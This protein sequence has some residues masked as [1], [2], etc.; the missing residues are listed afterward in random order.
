MTA[1]F[2]IGVFIALPIAMFVAYALGRRSGRDE[3]EKKLSGEKSA[4]SVER[5]SLHSEAKRNLAAVESGKRKNIGAAKAL[6]SEQGKVAKQ[7]RDLEERERILKEAEDETR[8]RNQFLRNYFRRRNRIDAYVGR[9][10]LRRCGGVYVISRRD[11]L[12]KVGFTEDDF[13][14]RFKEVEQDC[15]KAGI[16][17]LQPEILVPMDEGITEVEKEVHNGFAAQRESG[18]WFRVSVED[19]VRAVRA[20][21]WRQHL[22]NTKD[23]KHLEPPDKKG[24]EV[25]GDPDIPRG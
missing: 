22:R 5:E 13:S 25:R 6:K 18:E 7:R 9:D 11:G 23:R 15:R 14:R 20:A 21:A 3:A 24:D 1:E 4:M 16:V 10:A 19:A 2:I 12:V 8:E 17:G